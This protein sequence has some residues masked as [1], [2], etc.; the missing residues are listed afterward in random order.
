MKIYPYIYDTLIGIYLHPHN[1]HFDKF[2]YAEVRDGLEKLR[3][4]LWEFEIFSERD[5]GQK[6]NISEQM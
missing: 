5:I 2:W 6:K 4:K 1:D 3:W